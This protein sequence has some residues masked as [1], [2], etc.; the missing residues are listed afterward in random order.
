MKI[1][2]EL[3]SFSLEEQFSPYPA[4]T[5]TVFLI[6]SRGEDCLWEYWDL[7]WS[8]GLQPGR[9]LALKQFFCHSC[10]RH[11]IRCMERRKE[12]AVKLSLLASPLRQW[13]LSLYTR[14]FFIII[15]FLWLRI[16]LA[17]WF[18][19]VEAVRQ[20]LSKQN[21]FFQGGNIITMLFSPN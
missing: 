4:P 10:R 9:R 6:V 19:S 2:M 1:I 18:L 17:F 7:L 14:L 3:G 5:S 8:P 15:S 12:N 16:S 20:Y 11:V 21:L 13:L